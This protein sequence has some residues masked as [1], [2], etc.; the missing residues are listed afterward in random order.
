VTVFA[1]GN[2]IVHKGHGQTQLATAPDV[3][4]TPSPG[5][6]VPIPYPNM[7]PDSNLTNGAATVT[8]GGNPVANTD[9]QLS[10]SSG[11]EAGTAGGV[12]S[13]KNMGAFGWSAGS[14][15]VEAEGKG[16]VRMLDPI[17]TNGNAYND[18]GI[19][20]GTKQLGYGDD[21]KCPRPVCKLDH[22]LPKHR[23]VETPAVAALCDEFIAESKKK[24][25]HRLTPSGGHGR[26]VGVGLCMCGTIFKAIS[27]PPDIPE[28]EQAKFKPKKPKSGEAVIKM[29]FCNAVIPPVDDL[30]FSDIVLESNRKWSCAALK[31][32]T[33]AAGHFL[34]ALSEKWVGK[35]DENG[36]AT[37]KTFSRQNFRFPI[38]TGPE[39]LFIAPIGRDDLVRGSDGAPIPSGGSVPSCG[40]CQALLPALVCEMKPCGGGAGGPN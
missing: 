8:I 33:N 32:L 13:S 23:I 3:C 1:N 11:D 39:S 30:F 29:Q 19:T 22:E 37:P 35:E 20:G 2:S 9:S 16:V 10:R 34:L 4:K 12:V 27:G 7:S 21:A 28:G 25:P 18:V 6:P 31:I 14:I 5:G 38:Q 15:D 17:L 40:Q 36:V 24:V 26:M